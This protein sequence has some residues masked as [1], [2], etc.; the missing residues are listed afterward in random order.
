MPWPTTFVLVS[1]L[2]KRISGE[3]GGNDTVTYLMIRKCL[4]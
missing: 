4:N 2:V 1:T 3:D